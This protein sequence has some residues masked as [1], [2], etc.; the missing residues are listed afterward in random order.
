MSGFGCWS[1]FHFSLSIQ[2]AWF[3]E[4]YVEAN[5]PAGLC[6]PGWLQYWRALKMNLNAQSWLLRIV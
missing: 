2:L 6:T 3:C 5:D 1:P 4:E